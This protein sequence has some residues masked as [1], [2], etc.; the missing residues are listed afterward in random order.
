MRPLIPMRF[1][2]RE[3][4]SL[5][6]TFSKGTAPCLLDKGD[7]PM[8]ALNRDAGSLFS[9]FPLENGQSVCNPHYFQQPLRGR[10]LFPFD[11]FVWSKGN[12]P[13]TGWHRGI[14][15]PLR[16]AGLYLHKPACRYERFEWGAKSGSEVS[17][18]REA[19]LRDSFQFCFKNAQLISQMSEKASQERIKISKGGIFGFSVIVCGFILPKKRRREMKSSIQIEFLH[20]RLFRTFD[21]LPLA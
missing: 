4:S 16:P 7:C 14:E 11:R 10:I 6:M 15:F 20:V 13:I 3:A 1:F 18:T 12:R 17:V 2:G 5:M 9:S 8:D 19:F 21:L